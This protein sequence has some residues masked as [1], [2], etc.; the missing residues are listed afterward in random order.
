MAMNRFFKR[1]SLS[2]VI[3]LFLPCLAFAAGGGPV[4]PM[5]I[6]ADTR[7]LDGI[8][9]LWASMYNESHIQFTILTVVIIPVIGVIFGLLADIVMKRIGIDL[10][11]RDLAEH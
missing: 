3:S 7:Q 8:M 6:V 5:V 2:S 11:S 9:K 4:A 1:L 10:G